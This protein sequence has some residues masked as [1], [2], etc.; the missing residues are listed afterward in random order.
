MRKMRKYNGGDTL[1]F[2]LNYVD[3]FLAA[4]A[5]VG[6]MVASIGSAKHRFGLEVTGIVTTVLCAIIALYYFRG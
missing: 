1:Q 5:F 6:V 3:I 2:L 4:G